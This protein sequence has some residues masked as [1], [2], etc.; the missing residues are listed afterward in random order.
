MP[1]ARVLRRLSA[2][3][4]VALPAGTTLAQRPDV[5]RGRVTGGA[6]TAG[7]Q[8]ATISVLSRPDSVLKQARTDAKGLYAITVDKPGASYL[9]SVTMLGY[10]PQRRTV[11]RQGDSM[12]P[13]DFKL[14]P[15]AAQLAAVRSTGE[16]P[17]P[18]RGEGTEFSPGGQVSFT[19]LSRGTTGDVTGDLSAALAMLPGI[20]VIP[21]ATG[22]IPTVSAFGQGADQN[23]VV[24][25]NLGFSSSPPR[26][27][28]NAFVQSSNYDPGR[29]GFAGVQVSLRMQSGSN[30]LQRNIHAT[31]DAPSLQWTSPI[32][33]RL[34]TRYD[35]QVVSGVVSGPLVYDKAFYALSYQV[36]HRSSGLS[37]LYSADQAALLAL[38][39]SPDSVAQ[40]A[41]GTSGSVLAQTTP[42]VALFAPNYSLS[43]SWRPT[44]NI[45]YRLSSNINT[46]VGSTYVS[47]DAS[48]K[49]AAFRSRRGK[50]SI[51]RR[52]LMQSFSYVPRNFL[53][54]RL[55]GLWRSRP[56]RACGT[57]SIVASACHQ[58]RCEKRA[59]TN[60]QR[61]TWSV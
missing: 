46:T 14:V 16:R 42:P 52:Q 6:D 36:N 54:D 12:P 11:A 2:A 34:S 53:S 44:V 31:I 23:S 19:D 20:T 9:V 60:P 15:V 48:A 56:R 41:D 51:S 58:E 32:A 38:H 4:L 7:I 39:V 25:S 43:R 22:G 49:A 18:P 8:N 10:A 50:S 59:S 47:V 35:Q 27:G 55:R 21:S 24:L 29:G 17:R 30:F 5:I 61:H 26:D 13:V 1:F 33:S 37:N 45:N 28:F 3:V 57:Y 40:C